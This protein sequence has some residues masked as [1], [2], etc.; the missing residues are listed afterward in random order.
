MEVARCRDRVAGGTRIRDHHAERNLRIENDG[1]R[2]HARQRKRES[3]D[4]NAHHHQSKTIASHWT[5]L[6]ESWLA[7]ILAARRVKD[8]RKT[9]LYVTSG[10]KVEAQKSIRPELPRARDIDGRLTRDVR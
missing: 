2:C 9:A 1:C 5:V 6:H 4:R 7:S 8:R 10:L 3:Q